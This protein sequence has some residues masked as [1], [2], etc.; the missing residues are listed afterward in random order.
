MLSAA[1]D[2]L[3]QQG[4]AG[5]AGALG[6]VGQQVGRDQ[7]GVQRGAQLVAHHGQE[8]ALGFRG[9][10]GRV[11]GQGQLGGALLN[12]GIERIAGVG[13]AVGIASHDQAD[14][15]L[16]PRDTEQ[17]DQEGDLHQYAVDDQ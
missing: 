14:A 9:G 16:E 4:V 5:I 10:F 11:L 17:A 8:A 2:G 15:M 13:G 6:M 3:D 1:V 7:H 12:P